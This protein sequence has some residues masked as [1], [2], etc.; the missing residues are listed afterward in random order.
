MGELGETSVARVRG[1]ATEEMSPG[2]VGIDPDGVFDGGIGV[3]GF[4]LL[5]LERELGREGG[6]LVAERRREVRWV[7]GLGGFEPWREES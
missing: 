6:G 1:L 2:A 3:L 7:S 5:G 4:G